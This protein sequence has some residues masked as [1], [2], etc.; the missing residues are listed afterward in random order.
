MLWKRAQNNNTI[1]RKLTAARREYKR[2]KRKAEAS[3]HLR[4]I[5]NIQRVPM[6]QIA[7]AVKRNMK[8]RRKKGDN[9]KKHVAQLEPK[10]FTAFMEN[11]GNVQ[12]AEELEAFKGFEGTKIP[13]DLDS[14]IENAI[15]DMEP[16][17][18]IG[19]DG[20]HIE[21][22]KKIRKTAAKVLK[23]LWQAIGRTGKIP[24]KWLKGLLIPVH[25]KGRQDDPSNYHPQCMLSHPR[26]VLEKAYVG[27][28]DQYFETD[29]VQFAFQ[30]G[31]SILQG[32]LEVELSRLKEAKFFA[33]LDLRKAYDKVVKNILKTKLDRLVP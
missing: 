1:T 19:L 13:V 2:S 32:E 33:I 9:T 21:M 24:M 6:S 12:T 29:E 8:V 4:N 31:L 30:D 5:E 10:R 11:V 25:K 27:V 3:Y 22:I 18:E 28:L 20:I 7:E 23:R 15:A 16:N 14:R 26:K 17:K